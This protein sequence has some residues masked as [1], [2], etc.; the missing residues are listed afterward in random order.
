MRLLAINALNAVLIVAVCLAWLSGRPAS[1]SNWKLVKNAGGIK[2][3][4]RP[5]RGSEYD[6]FKGVTRIRTSLENLL[7]V[8]ADTSTNCEWMHRC[9][10]PTV[11]KQVSFTDRYIYQINYL[12]APLWNRDII[13]HSIA[14][15]NRR[16]DEVMI[17]L[18]AA[19]GFCD[20]HRL[21][22]C[23][24]LDRRSAGREFV[25][26]SKARGLYR[27]RKLSSNLVEFTWQ[28]HAEPGGDV[29]GWMSNL[30]IV[31]IPFETLKGLRRFL[32]RR[33]KARV[34]LKL[35]SDGR[36]IGIVNKR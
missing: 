22:A 15:A 17:R 32:T 23:R 14:T 8:M 6:A 18:K 28:M 3:Y 9:G 26:I 5:V 7:A 2:V 29:A 12:P 25:R 31:E 19:P 24:N 33:G 11:L 30:N 20:K 1:A 34:R 10:R 35:A 21:R 4:T 27:L 13:I 36:V 16:G